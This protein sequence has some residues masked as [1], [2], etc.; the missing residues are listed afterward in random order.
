MPMLP[1]FEALGIRANERT[2]RG[3]CP[4]HGGS[5][6]TAFAWR[7]DG[8][9][10]CFS[11][12]AGGDKIALVQAIRKCSFREAVAFLAG[13]VGVK[14]GSPRV[15]RRDLERRAQQRVRAQQAA[16][17][18]ADEIG[19]L[20]RYYADALHRTERLQKW[21]GNDILKMGTE[22][23]KE[24]V[25]ERLARLAPVCAYFF[26]AWNFIWDAKPEVLARFALAQPAE[27]RSTILD[28]DV[29]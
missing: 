16:W 18:I 20:R 28:G 22:P 15:S 6:P 1:L 21:L 11:C 3:S 5:N 19:R 13:L 29:P 10:H 14:L 2:R 8:R 26:A 25:W 23:A 17:R 27:R 4:I 9:W 24:C 12:G 7:D